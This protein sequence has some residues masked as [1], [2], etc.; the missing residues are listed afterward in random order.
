MN[1]SAQKTLRSAV[2]EFSQRHPRQRFQPTVVEKFKI[3]FGT[4]VVGKLEKMSNFN[5][6]S[7][8]LEGSQTFMET[9]RPIT[10]LVLNPKQLYGN[11]HILSTILISVCFVCVFIS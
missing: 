7:V 6:S 9:G 4:N 5:L 1:G 2:H 11:P 10:V 8:Q 3:C